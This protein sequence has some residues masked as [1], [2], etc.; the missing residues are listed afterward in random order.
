MA[1]YQWKHGSRIKGD[2]QAAGE[3]CAQLER[4][5]SLTPASL[6][7]ASRNE[8]A[9]LHGMFEWRDEIAAEKYREVQAGYIIRSVEVVAEGDSK[10]VRAFVALEIT[11]T[12]GYTST[13]VALA[14]MDTRE[15]VL[16]NA[17][18]ELREFERKYARLKELAGV[19]AAI[20]EVA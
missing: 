4:K 13:E 11:G 6:V 19:I 14:A 16:E 1:V 18:R 17:L 12:S 15:I 5:C 8:D 2:A 9:P 7:Q 20:K 10:P 3:V